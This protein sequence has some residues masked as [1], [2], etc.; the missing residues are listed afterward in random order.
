MPYS[1]IEQPPGSGSNIHIEFQ[2]DYSYSLERALFKTVE[3]GMPSG[4][5]QLAS[6]GHSLSRLKAIEGLIVTESKSPDKIL[7]D[8]MD[9]LVRQ[10]TS[11]E[12]ECRLRLYVEESG[13]YIEVDGWVTGYSANRDA[14]DGH[15]VVQVTFDF[16]IKSKN[17]SNLA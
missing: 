17:T 8:E 3:V 12:K 1:Y 2:G 16:L 9:E 15:A 13:G 10:Y 5:A 7:W 6:G 14:V 4:A 11:T